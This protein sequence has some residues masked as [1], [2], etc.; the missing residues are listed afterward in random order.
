MRRQIIS[1]VLTGALGV[2]L[3]V[4]PGCESDPQVGSASTGE[5][6]GTPGAERQ[7]G[8]RQSGFQPRTA[9]V[10]DTP[11]PAPR[12]RPR[13]AG[14]PPY[15]PPVGASQSSASLAFPTGE[16][17]SSAIAVHTVM[18]VEVQ[19]NELFEYSY[20]VNNL[21]NGTLQNVILTVT[22]TE[23][24]RIDAASP[25]ATRSG[26]TVFWNLGDLAGC[27][28]VEVKVR[29]SASDLGVASN[30][31][32]VAYNNVL[33]A[34]TVV[35]EPALT[36]AKTATPRAML[37]DPIVYTYTVCNTGTGVASN[38]VVTDT[39][40][41]GVTV[42]GSNTITR[43]F[44]SLAA[45][46]CQEFSVTADS[47]NTGEFASVATATAAGGLQASSE[48]PSTAVVQP[49]LTLT[50]DCRGQQ[51]IGRPVTYDLT[52]RNGGNGESA[53]TTVFATVPAGS[54]FSSATNGGT[55][56]GNRV[57]WN[58]GTVN[59]GA[60]SNFSFTVSP[61]G[62]G[63]LTMNAE[64]VGVCADTVV[65]DCTTEV[66]GIPAI[67][68]ECVDLTDPV[69]LGTQT[70]YVI[71]VTNQGSATD[72]NVRVV[73][74]LP[75]EQ[76][77][78]SASGATAATADGQTITFAPLP[79]LAPGERREFRVTIEAVGAGDVRFAVTM[80]SDEFTR[81]IQETESTNQYE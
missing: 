81:P 67:L 80:T 29:A 46:Q 33:C 2:A 35:V 14:C 24:L 32:E 44:A 42:N 15:S 16:F 13:T 51:F 11:A 43:E 57:V 79:S 63:S 62:S 40:P 20:F 64:A 41:A 49:V 74:E 6:I 61:A 22:E 72:R 31:V 53:N 3:A 25:A 76:R 52:L 12:P 19:R 65:T 73:V 54:T 26:N 70:T 39:L 8:G 10:R 7:G 47:A 77:F 27:D 68:L 60:D 21:N 55:L 59:P 38:V 69:E 4:L 56:Q 9:E 18:P 5:K 45:G 36:L 78:V 17:D 48:R 28:T 1:S 37:C 34:S 75:T 58:L 71:S 30:C 50:S 23:N 66:V